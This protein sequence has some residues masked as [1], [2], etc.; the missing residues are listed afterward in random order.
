MQRNEGG[1]MVRGTR[2]E[3]VRY[4]RRPA[5]KKAYRHHVP[6][7]R[8]RAVLP[9]FNAVLCRPVPSA[10]YAGG[11]GNDDMVRISNLALFLL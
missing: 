3:L 10:L 1:R 8:P 11:G 9:A 7:R 4:K 5:V 2:R 6:G